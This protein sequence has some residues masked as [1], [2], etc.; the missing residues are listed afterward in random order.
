MLR[1]KTNKQENVFGFYGKR[2]E[3]YHFFVMFADAN[4]ACIYEMT[5]EKTNT[6]MFTVLLYIHSNIYIN[7][8]FYSYMCF[9]QST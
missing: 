3:C 7:I 4:V 1:K 8:S 5:P 6:Q 2:P 9:A